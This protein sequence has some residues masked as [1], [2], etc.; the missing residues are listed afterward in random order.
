MRNLP[1][2]TSIARRIRRWW[3]RN[4]LDE[5][6][7]DVEKVRVMRIQREKLYV[8]AVLWVLENTAE[9]EDV[10]SVAGNIPLLTQLESIRL[11][12]PT[13]QFTQLMHEFTSS[14]VVIST[15][16]PRR[17]PVGRPP[18]SVH[19]SSRATAYNTHA[20][21]TALSL[22]RAIAHVFLA[23]PMPCIW[24]F[25][26]DA[27]YD[28]LLRFLHTD[29]NDFATVSPD[30]FAICFGIFEARFDR[31]MDY[32]N[33]E[34]FLLR[35]CDSISTLERNTIF[36]VASLLKI[37]PAGIPPALLSNEE[38]PYSDGF[39][40]LM[41]MEIVEALEGA[42]RPLGERVVD[43]RSAGDR[44]SVVQHM[45]LALRAHDDQISAGRCRKEILQLHSR[46]LS[47][48][49][50]CHPN[51]IDSTS[52]PYHDPGMLQLAIGHISRV[53]HLSASA[54]P[55][56]I[57]SSR[58]TGQALIRSFPQDQRVL[59]ECAADLR[60]YAV[61]LLLSLKCQYLFGED[62]LLVGLEQLVGT[63]EIVNQLNSHV[64]DNVDVADML[65]ILASQFYL[66]NIASSNLEG[67]VK[68][69]QSTSSL[70]PLLI[71]ILR[72]YTSRTVLRAVYELLNAITSF[73]R[74]LEWRVGREVS[75]GLTFI[76]DDHLGCMVVQ[77]LVHN[78]AEGNFLCEETER[79]THEGWQRI[80]WS[81]IVY[82]LG[83]I[84]LRQ[85]QLAQAFEQSEVVTLF[86]DTVS[87]ILQIPSNADS[88]E[89]DT[90]AWA[91]MLFLRTWGITLNSCS[92]G[93]G[94]GRYGTSLMSKAALR[95]LARY[96]LAGPESHLV[97]I[98]D[99]FADELYQQTFAFIEHAFMFRPNLAITCE[100][101][102]AC[103]ALIP[104]ISDRKRVELTNSWLEKAR[105]A[106]KY[107]RHLRDAVGKGWWKFGGL[108][109]VCGASI[110]NVL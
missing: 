20:I 73:E 1:L 42:Q 65:H 45:D 62:R 80:S 53:L 95:T 67:L 68:L 110:H 50:R 89:W 21:A 6:Y 86:V 35:V 24:N 17:H 72:L 26:C 101:D 108:N 87:E 93:D 12:P 104:S 5:E 44:R 105:K 106:Y 75:S 7:E 3:W 36:T 64:T 56:T 78:L 57:I 77:T 79:Y 61:Q 70:S 103:D 99:P 51:T 4:R 23:D 69:V 15:Q 46:V 2:L 13:P 98:P 30:L 83:A 11:V 76:I 8:Q 34:Q 71:R 37:S 90:V 47:V 33:R 92:K 25:I 41:C 48:F 32:N 88:S 63:I 16:R 52:N 10:L 84:M 109:G 60:S 18:A 49:R 14:L 74:E 96:M 59:D 19:I 82:S 29:Y 91:T 102:I 107:G 22:G 54:Q 38:I 31:P 100:L 85:P 28:K 81:G 94:D 58:P 9:Q 43:I 66:H 40:S 55:S 39:F 27:F 97:N